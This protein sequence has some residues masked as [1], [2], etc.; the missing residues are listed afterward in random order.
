MRL[1]LPATAFIVAFALLSIGAVATSSTLWAS[2]ADMPVS[3]LSQTLHLAQ[4][5]PAD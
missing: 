5:V 3:T 4:I 1:T 2:E